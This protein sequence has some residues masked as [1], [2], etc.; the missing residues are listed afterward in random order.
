MRRRAIVSVFTA[1]LFVALARQTPVATVRQLAPGVFSRQGDRDRRPANYV[2][3]AF[4][5]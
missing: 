5:R 1:L 4:Y 3:L 2:S